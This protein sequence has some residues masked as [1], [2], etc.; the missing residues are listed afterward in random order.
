MK[1]VP[2][3]RSEQPRRV[4]QQQRHVEKTRKRVFDH[5]GRICGCCGAEEDLSIDHINGDGAEHREQLTGDRRR[6]SYRFYLW[7]IRNGYPEGFQVL[8]RRCNHSKAKTGR[9]HLIH[10]GTEGVKH[11][12]HP[13]HEGPNP[14]PLESFHRDRRTPDGRIARCKDCA[15]RFDTRPRKTDRRWPRDAA[16]LEI[17]GTQRAVPDLLRIRRFRRRYG[18]A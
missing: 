12:S 7:L 2:L 4:S 18:Q 6:G 17:V 8:C 9:C 15:R 11:C 13:Q 1:T 5:Y 14:L 3:P 16:A 10:D